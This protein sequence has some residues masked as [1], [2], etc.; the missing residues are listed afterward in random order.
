MATIP[1]SHKEDSLKLNP[2]EFIQLFDIT[3]LSGAK[4]LAHSGPEIQWSPTDVSNPLTF[5]EA[6]IKVS[7]AGRN[8]GE[9]RI[10]PT[11][12]IGNPNDVFHVPV[13]EG[14]LD[15]AIVI[16][17]KVKPENLQADPPVFEKNTWYI[18]QVPALGEVITA[19]LRS[20][21]D[22]Q[23]GMIPTRQFLKPEFPSVT[24]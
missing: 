20:L 6:F 18:A 22:R 12:T 24:I 3:L 14:H 23:E 5:E 8:S 15:G 13:A 10:R 9:K 21:S 1:E 4:I 2:E 7:N 19:Q 11:L 16:R 17:Y